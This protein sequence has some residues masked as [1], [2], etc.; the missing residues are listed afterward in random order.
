[1]SATDGDADPPL[2]RKASKRRFSSPQQDKLRARPDAGNPALAE[3]RGMSVLRQP[4][5]TINTSEFLRRH[6][7]EIIHDA[8]TAL[9]RL[10]I[11]HYQLAEETEVRQRLEALFDHLADSLGDHD[12]GPMI[13][14]AESIAEERFGSGYDL[15]EVQAAFNALE[16]STWTRAVAMLDPSELAEVLGLVSTVLGCGKDALARRYVSLATRTHAPAVDLRALSRG[17]EGRN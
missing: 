11:R 4:T 14:Y 6:R 10:R 3:D 12:V 17:G 9:A 16:E 15:S 5:A 2:S 13:A 1:M 7:H 8:N